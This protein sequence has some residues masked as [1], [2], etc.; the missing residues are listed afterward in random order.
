MNRYVNSGKDVISAEDIKNAILFHG[1]SGNVKVSVV[2]IDKSE[3]SLEQSKI[4]N[5]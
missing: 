5:I 1:G 3:C 2:E 4:P